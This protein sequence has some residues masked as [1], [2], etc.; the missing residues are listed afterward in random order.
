M[1]I[2]DFWFKKPVAT[3]LEILLELLFSALVI[4]LGSGFLA[5]NKFKIGKYPPKNK[6]IKR[7]G[8]GFIY[9]GA[10]P[11]VITVLIALGVS[12]PGI[13]LAF[14]L[15]GTFCVLWLSY[16]FYLYNKKIKNEIVNYEA[17]LL[18]KQYLPK[19]GRRA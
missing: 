6:I 19:R 9:F 2:L 10:I 7:F 4:V 8:L 13:R 17:K 16:F 1:I 11:L 15:V 18:Q 3:G 14:L 12:F 5:F